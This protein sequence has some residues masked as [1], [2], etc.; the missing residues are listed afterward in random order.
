MK[1]HNDV[2]ERKKQKEE[3]V[4]S[5]FHF[6]TISGS[7]IDNV[8]IYTRDASSVG[9]HPV[10][11]RNGSKRLKWKRQKWNRQSLGK[12]SNKRREPIYSLSIVQRSELWSKKERRIRQISNCKRENDC[13]QRKK[14]RISS[15]WRREEPR[16]T[17]LINAATLRIMTKVKRKIDSRRR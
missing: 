13:P 1:F 9:N 3:Q 8:I 11:R 10:K 4:L 17:Q 12:K 14:R 15:R 16:Q 7:H 5:D 2:W 6:K